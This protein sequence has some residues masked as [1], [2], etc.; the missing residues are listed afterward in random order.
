MRSSTTAFISLVLIAVFATSGCSAIVPKRPSVQATDEI[1]GNV[2]GSTPWEKVISI[3]KIVN[4]A[5]TSEEKSSWQVSG[6]GYPFNIETKNR[7]ASLHVSY[8][9]H[10]LNVQGGQPA[11]YDSLNVKDKDL[12]LYRRLLLSLFKLTFSNLPASYVFVTLFWP[13]GI[14]T[15]F[16]VSQTDWQDY[17]DGGVAFEQFLEQHS[18]YLNLRDLVAL[19]NIL[20]NNGVDANSFIPY[21]LRLYLEMKQQQQQTKPAK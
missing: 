12:K 19:L 14:I 7:A 9:V 8:L 6:I 20:Q 17:I 15:A 5:R 16:Q 21:A 2:T 10:I 3:I 13:D 18:I 11:I 1:T 4:D